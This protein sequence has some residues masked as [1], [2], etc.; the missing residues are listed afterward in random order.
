[1]NTRK[2]FT[3]IWK[4]NAVIILLAGLLTI[5]V[6]AFIAFEEATRTRDVEHVA[7]IADTGI[8]KSKTELTDF[9]DVNGTA[10]M[11]AELRVD[12][13]Y[14][15]SSGSKQA[16]SVRN[17]LFFDSVNKSTHWLRNDNKGVIFAFH[18]LPVQSYS[19]EDKDKPIVAFLYLIAD[20]DT[21]NDKRLTESDLK[22]IAVSD[23]TG[24]RFK[25]V[26]NGIDRF[27][28]SRFQ[29]NGHVLILYTAASHLKVADLDLQTQTLLS[30][31]E[32]KTMDGEK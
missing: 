7:N 28:G 27:N 15:F 9:T 2:L 14:A 22:D 19:G 24:K 4:I 25:V 6:L 11:R 26:I 30:D 29:E 12:Q 20:K 17:Y 32:A 10:I 13:E 1:M 8:D 21:N 16:S 5:A 23:A 18:S 31:V 3:S